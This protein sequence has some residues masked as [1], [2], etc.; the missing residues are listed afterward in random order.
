MRESDMFS[1]VEFQSEGATLRGRLYRDGG[2]VRRRP[3]VIMAH[4]LSASDRRR[5]D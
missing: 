2:A 4:G 1:I 5:R 3:A